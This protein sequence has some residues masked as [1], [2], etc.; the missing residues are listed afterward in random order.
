[1]RAKWCHQNGAHAPHE[2][3]RQGNP[4]YC[5]G[6]PQVEDAEP[7]PEALPEAEDL[8][9]AQ[10]VDR[11]LNAA[12]ENGYDIWSPD[13]NALAIDL[14]DYDADL[15]AAY[16]ELPL[17]SRV[18]QVAHLVAAWR[19]PYRRLYALLRQ[20]LTVLSHLRARR[21]DVVRRRTR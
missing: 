1:M 20:N 10:L 19:V 2:W 12:I 13:A 4:L 9:V 16:E 21:P 6:G 15:S 17:G 18:S 8:T 5:P 11:A 3:G 14:L 7:E